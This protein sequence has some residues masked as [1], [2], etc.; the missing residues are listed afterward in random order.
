MIAARHSV[1]SP[2]AVLAVVNR[3]GASFDTGFVL[4]D[5]MTLEVCFL[6]Q[7]GASLSGY[8]LCGHVGGGNDSR[9][10]RMFFHADQVYLDAGGLPNGGGARGAVH[11]SRDEWHTALGPVGG[12]FVVDGSVVWS[13]PY[14]ADGGYGVN[15]MSMRVF[16]DSKDSQ[17]SAIRYI[18]VTRYGTG[19]ILCD[20]WPDRRGGFVDRVSKRLILPSAGSVDVVDWRKV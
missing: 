11:I 10:F 18:T 4:G 3:G 7:A 15:G 8:L 9:D 6:V 14:A 13:D 20:L 19:E 12:H 16:G 1:S 17:T 2:D 5:Y